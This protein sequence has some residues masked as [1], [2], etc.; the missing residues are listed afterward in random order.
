M[1]QASGIPCLTVRSHEH[2]AGRITAQ[3][4]L[5]TYAAQ[6]NGIAQDRI[7]QW[8]DRLIDG[9][10][11]IVFVDMPPLPLPVVRRIRTHQLT[12]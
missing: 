4:P 10:G 6:E 9:E 5:A 7:D 12:G 8:L 1:C 11:G 2:S 3:T